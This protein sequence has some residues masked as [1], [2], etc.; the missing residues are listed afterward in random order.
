MSHVAELT[1]IKIAAMIH[2]RAGY[3]RGELPEPIALSVDRKGRLTLVFSTQE[4]MEAWKRLLHQPEPV[5]TWMLDHEEA[6]QG[7]LAEDNGRQRLIV[8]TVIWRAG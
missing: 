8:T 6:W 4:D 1:P 3:G 7:G 2:A 5:S